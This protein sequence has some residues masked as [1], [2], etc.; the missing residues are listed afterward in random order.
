MRAV[1]LRR[2]LLGRTESNTRCDQ[3]VEY[4]GTGGTRCGVSLDEGRVQL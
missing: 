4:C 1:L 2:V 3:L